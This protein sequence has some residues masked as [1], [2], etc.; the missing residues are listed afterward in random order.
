MHGLKRR[1]KGLSKI[2]L[3]L[4]LLA[5]QTLLILA[6]ALY[7]KGVWMEKFDA[8]RTKKDDFFLLNGS[9]VQVWFMTSWERQLVSA[10]DG[11][12][13]LGLP[14]KQ[15]K[16][17]RCFSM[18]FFLPDARDG[19][20]ALVEKVCS[21]SGFLDRHLPNK[22]KKMGDFMIPKFKI[23]FGFQVSKILK[24]LG[25][26]LLFSHHADLT[27]MVGKV[28]S[29]SDMFHQSFIEVD[30]E[31]TKAAAV[32]IIKRL[33]VVDSPLKKIHRLCG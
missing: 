30:E 1:L 26:A 21:E 15:G 7:F 12:K 28:Y 33:E 9:S 19:L 20:P 17:K 24:E 29:V 22:R 8:S 25:L 6:N 3:L 23:T 5:A 18:Y 31:G 14:Y 27:E 2:F 10:F 16:D 32:T 13:V 4:G 11:F